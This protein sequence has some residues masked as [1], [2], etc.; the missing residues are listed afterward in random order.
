MQRAGGDIRGLW[1]D[2]GRIRLG[3]EVEKIGGEE[4]GKEAKGEFYVFLRDQK[5]C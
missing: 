4:R 3:K 2:W 5:Y 1:R